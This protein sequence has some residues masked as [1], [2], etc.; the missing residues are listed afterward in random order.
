[1]GTTCCT[2]SDNPSRPTNT[3]TVPSRKRYRHHTV[4]SVESDSEAGTDYGPKRRTVGFFGGSGTKVIPPHQDESYIETTPTHSAEVADHIPIGGSPIYR[5]D[6]TDHD[7]G[8]ALQQLKS[9][10][11]YHTDH[12][13]S[14]YAKQEQ[15]DRDNS[16]TDH[17]YENDDA[18][19]SNTDEMDP[20]DHTPTPKD[21]TALIGHQSTVHALTEEEEDL[22]LCYRLFKGLEVKDRTYKFQTFPH[23]FVGEECV[24]FMVSNNIAFTRCQATERAQKLV[25][26]RLVVHVDDDHV[27]FEDGSYLYCFV[28]PQKKLKNVKSRYGDVIRD[29]E[30]GI[31]DRERYKLQQMR[32]VKEQCQ[33]GFEVKD[34]KLLFK[35]YRM[36][37][38]GE[39]AVSWMV[40]QKVATSRNEAVEIGQMFL[41]NKMI[42]HSN[43]DSVHFK[44]SDIFYEFIKS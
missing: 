26:A 33:K 10:A 37:F 7:H 15:Q 2:S 39:E 22:I 21:P 42:R 25:N 34:R 19:Y 17:Y 44:D 14:V 6:D 13:V 11:E 23:C 18:I 28:N 1:M 35:T 43:S 5:G 8:P 16:M 40:E 3:E 4:Q 31:Q 24:T 32:K 9:L 12:Y 41:D 20:E 27:G 30:G 36:C 29:R 38:V